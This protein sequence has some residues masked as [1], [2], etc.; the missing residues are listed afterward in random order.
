VRNGKLENEVGNWKRK[1]DNKSMIKSFLD[2][3][4]YKESFQLSLE[5]DKIIKTFPKEEQ[6][7][8]SDQSKRAS[9][10]SIQPIRYVG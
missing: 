3:D 1:C 4:V 2:L 7:L 8:L 5:I 9:R 10:A 6:Y